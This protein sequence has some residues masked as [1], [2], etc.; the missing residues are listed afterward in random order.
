MTSSSTNPRLLICEGRDCSVTV[1]DSCRDC[2]KEFCYNSIDIHNCSGRSQTTESSA[3]LSTFNIAPS[4]TPVVSK[5]N[6]F[7]TPIAANTN[8]PPQ[9]KAAFERHKKRAVAELL[10]EASERTVKYAPYDLKVPPPRFPLVAM[11]ASTSRSWV[12]DHS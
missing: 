5:I 3:G 11:N 6:L 10:Q 12:W 8:P 2:N 4:E 1:Y 7:F 9:T